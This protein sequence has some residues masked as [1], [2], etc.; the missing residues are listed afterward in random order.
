MTAVSIGNASFAV[1]VTK[2]GEYQEIGGLDAPRKNLGP[3]DFIII[4]FPNIAFSWK[5]T[6][7]HLFFGD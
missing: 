1:K 2:K 7:T 6:M 4:G 5:D 3:K